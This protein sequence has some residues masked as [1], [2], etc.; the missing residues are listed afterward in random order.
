MHMDRR[1]RRIRDRAI[2]VSVGERIGTGK[3][4]GWRVVKTT[5]RIQHQRAEARSRQQRRR[6]DRLRI[7]IR[8]ECIVRQ[9]T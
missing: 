5:I 3:T 6:G 7:T 4:R 9:Y 2:R 1:S 8:I